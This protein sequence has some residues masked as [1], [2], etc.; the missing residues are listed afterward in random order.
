MTHRVISPLSLLVALV[1]AG[2]ASAPRSDAVPRGFDR[3]PVRSSV[4]AAENEPQEAGWTFQQAATMTIITDIMDPSTGQPITFLEVIGVGPAEQLADLV[5][6]R[7]AGLPPTWGS[8]VVYSTIPVWTEPSEIPEGA[9]VIVPP[10]ESMGT[11]RTT[12]QETSRGELVESLWTFWD[13]GDLAGRIGLAQL[14][15]TGA[16]RF[17]NLEVGFREIPDPGTDAWWEVQKGA[18]LAYH[19][20]RPEAEAAAGARSA[21]APRLCPGCLA[22]ETTEPVCDGCMEHVRD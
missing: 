4:P 13:R 18:W 15:G 17:T 19:G 12:S 9:F 8:H 11:Y 21:R 10:A 14:S 20:L 5:A 7:R 1:L 22:F 3:A 6:Q 16:L 2:C